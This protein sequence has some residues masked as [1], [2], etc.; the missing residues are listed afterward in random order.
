MFYLSPIQELVIVI[1]VHIAHRALITSNSHVATQ[2]LST[3]S[4]HHKNLLELSSNQLGFSCTN[5]PHLKV[6]R[7]SPSFLTHKFWIQTMKLHYQGKKTPSVWFYPDKKKFGPFFKRTEFYI[8]CSLYTTML[9]W[10]KKNLF[11]GIC[12]TQKLKQNFEKNK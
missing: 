7:C 12:G 10:R 4:L 1:T 3:F 6:T 5:L 11:L 8:S 2:P 9:F